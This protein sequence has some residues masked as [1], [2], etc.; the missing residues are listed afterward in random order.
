V[1]SPWRDHPGRRAARVTEILKGQLPRTAQN[2]RNRKSSTV[3]V[4]TIAVNMGITLHTLQQTASQLK[5]GLKPQITPQG[6]INAV[7]PTKISAKRSTCLPRHHPR[8][9]F[10]RCMPLSSRDE[11][12]VQVICAPQKKSKKKTTI[13]TLDVSAEEMDYQKKV[14][15]LKN[16]VELT[17]EEGNNP[18]EDTSGNDS[19]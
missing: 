3:M 5:I 8:R 6:P 19:A 7:F 14:K 13:N 2:L 1:K 4:N 16:H 15:W 12:S 11:M 18:E 9:R 10:W 17:G